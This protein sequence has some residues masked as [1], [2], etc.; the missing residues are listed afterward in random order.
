MPDISMCIANKCPIKEFCYRFTAEEDRDQTFM[1]NP[2]FEEEDGMINCAQF[3]FN[4][5]EYI[6][7]EELLEKVSVI[8]KQKEGSGD[9][10]GGS[11]HLSHI[12][13]KITMAKTLQGN[14]L[15]IIIYAYILAIQ[16]EFGGTEYDRVDIV[17]VNDNLELIVENCLL[18]KF[19]K[20]RDNFCSTRGARLGREHRF[21]KPHYNYYI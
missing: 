19:E 6:E 5:V 3:W 20:Y 2:P 12:S 8:I 16:S 10:A 17:K 14:S 21:Y 15:P 4:Y 1:M 9:K 11:G 13:H 18:N 7:S